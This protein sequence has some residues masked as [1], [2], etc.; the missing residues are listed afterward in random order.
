MAT[1][2]NPQLKITLV[3]GSNQ[4]DVEAS[5][6]VSLTPL[7]QF[8]IANGLGLSVRCELWAADSG[9]NGEDDLVRV[10]GSRQ[11]PVSA[12]HTFKV[13]VPRGALD[14]DDSIFDDHDEL[15]AKMRLR[16]NQQAFPL[17]IT[18]KS[19]EVGGEF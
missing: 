5:V 11:V 14:E 19:P 16:S 17:D 15:Y 4:A 18:V 10:V 9:F 3:S 7:E 1:L 12:T 6:R 8:L 13:R 2:T